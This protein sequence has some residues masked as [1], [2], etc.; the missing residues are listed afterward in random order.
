M[1][2]AK[3]HPVAD[4][5]LSGVRVRNDV[6]CVQQ[7]AVA[8]PA[9]GAS[10]PICVDDAAPKLSLEQPLSNAPRRVLATKRGIWKVNWI[11]RWIGENPR[12]IDLDREHQRLSIVRDHVHR[13]RREVVARIR[14]IEI[15]QRGSLGE[16]TSKPNIVPMIWIGAP[17]C[18][19]EM[20]RRVVDV[21]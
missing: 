16:R 2:F 14:A 18:V 5:R 6:S 20:V 9:Q 8:Q 13:K 1:Q 4:D 21:V 17:I 11:D 12:L 15:D 7:F 10:L 19:P 3:R